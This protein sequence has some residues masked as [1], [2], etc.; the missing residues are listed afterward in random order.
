MIEIIIYGLLAVAVAASCFP[1]INKFNVAKL[2]KELDVP[3]D[4]ILR[5]HFLTQIRTENA[6]LAAALEKRLAKA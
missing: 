2:A 5:R 1:L 3:E 6:S 4:S